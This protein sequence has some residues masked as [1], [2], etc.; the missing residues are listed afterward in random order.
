MEFLTEGRGG[1]INEMTK[2]N[3]KSACLCKRFC[4]FMCVF[5]NMRRNVRR[6]WEIRSFA[7][8]GIIPLRQL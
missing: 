5:G 1:G 4:G 3:D 2:W 6:E 7:G 8:E